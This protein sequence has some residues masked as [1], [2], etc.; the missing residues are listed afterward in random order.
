MRPTHATTDILAGV[1]GLAHDVVD[2][3]AVAHTVARLRERGVVLPRLSWLADPSTM[4]EALRASTAGV[5]PDAADPRN[6][7]RIHWHN[8]A[9][10]SGLCDVPG[11]VVL[12]KSLTGVDAPIV[13]LL[14]ERFPMI[15]AHK[16]LAAYGVLVPR[17][18]NGELDPTNQKALWPS[19][20]NYCRGGVA[21]SRI[22]GTRGVAILPAGMSQERFDWLEHWVESPDEDIVRTPGT[23]SNVKEIYDTCARLG[24]QPDHVVLNQFAEYGNHLVHWL[25]TGRAAGRVFES[26][27]ASRPGLELF[28]FVS[29][30]GSAG[31]IAAGDYLKETYGARI[32]AVEALQCPTLL[33]NGY[34]EHQI[35]GI[36]D[37][38]VP[39]VHNAMNTDYVIAVDDRA[40]DALFALGATE[41]GRRYLGDRRGVDPETLAAMESFG[42]SGWANVLG[43]IEIARHHRLGPD[44]AIVTVATDGAA[45]YPSELPRV[46]RDGFGGRLDDVAA[47]EAFGRF[48]LGSAGV[49]DELDDRGRR[50]IF[51]LGYYTWVE[52][53]GVTFEHFEARRR[54]AF[55]RELRGLVQA[56][57]ER[58]DAV[59]AETGALAAL[60]A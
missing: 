49:L 6:L 60:G 17:L 31:T 7:F 3:T 32:G 48:V 36:G 13:V 8:D 11:H 24:A 4:P 21:V 50:R 43:A 10:R 15:G 14:G 45:L 34:G 54:Q 9:V 30:T 47:A 12:P 20:G 22:L 1:P 18:V 55:W 2:A 42:F 40:S 56:W 5:D 25:V 23:E 59:N 53:Q 35:Q 44:Q 51:Q 46:V 28:A 41:G 39:L 16:V 52:Q 26:V 33:E 58:I 29:A 19:T 27:A 57:D 37:K 38:H